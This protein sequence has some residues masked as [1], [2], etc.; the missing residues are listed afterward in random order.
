MGSQQQLVLQVRMNIVLVVVSLISLSELSESL[1][2]VG[3]YFS[4]IVS[5]KVQ[6]VD[7]RSD[8]SRSIDGYLEDSILASEY[9][10]DRPDISATINE[11]VFIVGEDPD[12]AKKVCDENVK[13]YKESM[14]NFPQS[15]IVF[16]ENIEYEALNILLEREE[17][18]FILID[19]R[20]SSELETLGRIPGSV[21]I[22]LYE[23]P[24][25]FSVEPEQFQ[26]KYNFEMPSTDAKNVVFTCRSG[27]R[28]KIAINRLSSLGYSHLRNYAGSYLDWKK[29]DG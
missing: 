15:Q 17:N 23:I 24:Q 7:V 5:G 19:V 13:C 12:L 21:N 22:P 29:N 2:L 20:N 27:R 18:G 3:P 11:V 10:T 8:L 6:T 25:A 16:P 9:S 1:P 14:K 28:S 4:A 26:S